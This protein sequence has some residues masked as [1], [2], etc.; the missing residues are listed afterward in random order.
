MERNSGDQLDQI[1]R[2][3]AARLGQPVR[4][5]SRRGRSRARVRDGVLEQAYPNVFTVLAQ[6]E[7]RSPALR[8]ASQERLSFSYSDLLTSHVRL[9]APPKD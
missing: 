8:Q 5:Y 3:V 6:P 4:V 9:S 1:R 7:A 2:Q